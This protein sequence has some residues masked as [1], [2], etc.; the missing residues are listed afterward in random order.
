MARSIKNT[1]A[2][3]LDFTRSLQK[4]QPDPFFLFIKQY[5]HPE[6]S[7]IYVYRLKPPIDR[8]QAGIEDSNIDIIEDAKIMDEDYLL[9][10]HGSGKYH[11]KFTDA[12]KPKGLTEVAKTTIEIYDPAVPPILNPVE[13][14]IG[15]PGN[16]KIVQK[17]IGEGWT[18]L[19]NK[20]TSPT[21][22]GGS[23]VLAETVR[24]LIKDRQRPNPENEG[25]A[26]RLVEVLERRNDGGLAELERFLA[27]SERLQPKADPVQ[28]EMMKVLAGM[29]R[30]TSPAA[31]KNPVE[32]LRN[33]AALLKEFGWGGGGGPSWVE[34]VNALPGILQYGALLLRELNTSK[35][36]APAAGSPAAPALAVGAVQ[37]PAE[38]EGAE[39]LGGLSVVEMKGLFDDAVDAFERGIGGA[40]F[41]HAVVCRRNGEKLYET[42][43]AIGKDQLLGFFAMMPGAEALKAR[44]PE[45]E[46]FLDD[47]IAYGE[48]EPEQKAS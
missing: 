14:V 44:R 46:K 47:F 1:E 39:M 32:E 45:I 18:V 16:D 29:A 35:A 10:T 28:V 3:P 37:Q 9:R 43:C 36:A 26:A 17:Y 48:P 38:E 34:A 42:V 8:R 21:R 22:D 25:I 20:L 30:G 5:P 23:A 31:E 6:G 4:L 27:L 11:L 2:A 33:T 7:S 13:L 24:D 15:A 40:D 12:N 41:A 19:D